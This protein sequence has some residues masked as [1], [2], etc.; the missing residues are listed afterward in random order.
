MTR[1][2]H[3]F[4]IDA[5]ALRDAEMELEFALSR[6]A[7][8]V[9]CWARK[10]GPGLCRI[11]DARAHQLQAAN[12]A[13]TDEVESLERAQRNS[14]EQIAELEAKLKRASDLIDKAAEA[15]V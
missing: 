15:V 7:T 8:A 4:D 5:Q 12:E 3:H 1:E 11:A 14:L 13:L 6:D 2:M 9:V 10:W